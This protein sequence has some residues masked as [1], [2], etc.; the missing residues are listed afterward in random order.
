MKAGNI[1]KS[2]PEN[3]TAEVFEELVSTSSV[4]IERIVSKGHVSPD[5]GWYDQAEHEWI[6]IMQGKA[7]LE[8]ED[9]VDIR[10]TK[11]P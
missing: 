10:V 8:F 1:L 9:C 4:R 2:L 3:L 5:I 6:M 11:L 7:T